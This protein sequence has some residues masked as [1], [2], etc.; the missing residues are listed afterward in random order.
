ML[1]SASFHW[2]YCM[3]QLRSILV[4][5]V[6]NFS[7]IMYSTGTALSHTRVLLFNQYIFHY[8]YENRK[9]KHLS[10]LSLR[11]HKCRR[12]IDFKIVFSEKI[13]QW[14]Q[15]D[16]EQCKIKVNRNIFYCYAKVPACFDLPLALSNLHVFYFPIDHNF[17]F[18]SVKVHNLN[19]KKY[20]GLVKKEE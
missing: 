17:K 1:R 4:Y 18:Q 5:N 20:F 9:Q 16:L 10:K 8:N 6:N 13:S 19:S 12:S 14:P 15:K 7:S 3:Q 11:D 2:L